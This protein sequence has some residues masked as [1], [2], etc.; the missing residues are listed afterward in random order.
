M[1]NINLDIFIKKKGASGP[2]AKKDMIRIAIALF[3]TSKSAT[4]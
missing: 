1:K 4:N 3:Q 2:K